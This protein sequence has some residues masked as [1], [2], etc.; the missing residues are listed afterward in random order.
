MP[1]CHSQEQL[2]LQSSAFWV[3]TELF[4]EGDKEGCGGLFL[5]SLWGDH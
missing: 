4:E 3:R 1:L 5:F 2:G